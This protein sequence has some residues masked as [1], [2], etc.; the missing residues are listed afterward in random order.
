MKPRNSALRVLTVEDE[1]L[2]G[3]ELEYLVAEAGHEAVGHALASGE[4]IEMLRDRSP[5]LALVDVH[6]LDGPTGIDV[7]RFAS[8]KTDTVVL[9]M[10]ANRKRIPEDFAGACGTIG[11]P[12]TEAGV[13]AA[14]H[15]I[16]NCLSQGAAS[17]PVPVSMELAP[18]WAER[19][20]VYWK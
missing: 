18:A 15:F 4:A 7:A 13:I 5:D 19:W 11:K 1:V 16:E 2:L 12:Y 9:F 14:L 8:E 3:V 17:G 10:T 6:L 20:G